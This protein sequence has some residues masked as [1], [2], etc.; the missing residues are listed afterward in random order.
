MAKKRVKP[1]DNCWAC[2]GKCMVWDTPR[3]KKVTCL[4]CNGTGIDP[5][6]AHLYEENVVDAN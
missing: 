1:E 2:D 6:K 5:E 4:E 3:H